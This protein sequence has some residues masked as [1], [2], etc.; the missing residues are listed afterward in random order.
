ML[1]SSIDNYTIEICN[2][3]LLNVNIINKYI[4]FGVKIIEF[5]ATFPSVLEEIQS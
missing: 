3:R 2:S 1:A 4:P 5:P